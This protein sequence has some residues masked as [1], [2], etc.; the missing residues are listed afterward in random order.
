M[1]FLKMVII[2]LLLNLLMVIML[3]CFRK[4]GVIGFLLL[5]GGFMVVMIWMLINFMGV[6]FF[7]LY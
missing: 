4:R 5:F 2:E 1:I 3:K 7:R 6:V